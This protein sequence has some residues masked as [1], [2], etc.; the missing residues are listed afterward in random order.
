MLREDTLQTELGLRL[1]CTE[2]QILTP[3]LPAPTPPHPHPLMSISEAFHRKIKQVEYVFGGLE[4]W[5]YFVV[6]RKGYPG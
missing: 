1:S 4:R 2:S 5:D 3:P 6:L